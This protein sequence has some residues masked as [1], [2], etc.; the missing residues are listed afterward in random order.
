MKDEAQIR[1]LILA[2]ESGMRDR[3]AERLVSRYAPDVVRYDL[4][5]PLRRTGTDLQGLRDWFA[6]FDGAI[7]FEIRDLDVTAGEEVAYAHSLNRLSATPHG[8]TE[9]FD[10]WFRATV[11]LRKIGGAW[12]ITHEHTSTPFYMDGSLRSAVDLQP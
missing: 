1:E 3:D 8:M 7:D 12:Q 2:E 10:L 9:P 6:G 5:P 4:A 11:C